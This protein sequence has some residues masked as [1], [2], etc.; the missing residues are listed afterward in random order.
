MTAL[1]PSDKQRTMKMWNY[2]GLTAAQIARQLQL[3]REAVIDW[4]L[5]PAYYAGKM[6]EFREKRRQQQRAFE[7]NGK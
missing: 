5:N 6:R 1:S 2:H 4:I 7:R 3:D